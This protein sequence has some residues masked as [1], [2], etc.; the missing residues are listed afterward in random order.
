MHIIRIALPLATALLLPG[1]DWPGF[2]GPSR[3]GV[4]RE[5]GIP[6]E[7]GPDKN[8]AWKTAIPGEGWSS[9]VVWKDRVYLT[10]ATEGGASCRLMALDARTG[11]L[12]W[13]RELARQEIKR[14]E[15]KNS[16]ASPTPVTDGR[17]VYCVC[18]D[19]TFAAVDGRGQVLWTNR[20]Y[21][22][23]S[24]HGLGSSPVLEGG[25]LIMARD[26]SAESG[27]LKVGWQKPWDRSYIV[28]LDR[29]TG[30]ERWKTGRGLSRIAHVTP[31]V[32]GEVLVSGAGDVVQGFNLRTGK[33]L[34][35]G[36]S[37]GE[38][39][40]PSIV[41]GDGLIYTVSGFEK[42]TIRAFRPDGQIAWEQTKGVPMIP[43]LLHVTPYLYSITINGI[44]HCYEA[45]T[46]EIVW[47]N[48]VG[49]NFSASPVWVDGHLLLASE[50]GE[51]IVIRAGGRFEEIARSSLGEMI[52]ASPA[53]SGG[54][55]FIRT[56]GTLWC[57]QRKP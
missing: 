18:G 9:P 32:M 14:K 44:A 52:Q 21:P 2:R 19:G 45:G 22:H 23:Y 13:D 26:G 53:I 3:Q 7:F 41:L 46:G 35:T 40:V 49:G 4:S 6:I 43:S 37:Q 42:P 31:N 48:R 29:K 15:K 10:T 51:I 38:G 12:L 47:Q 8:L 33:L 39:V 25:L 1:E 16:Y 20:D 24:Q 17:A 56:A 36:K 57:F 34:W 30:K 50:E 11:R 28:A 54:R 5:K 27:D 55:L